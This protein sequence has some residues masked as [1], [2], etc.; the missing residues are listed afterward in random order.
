ML[1]GESGVPVVPVALIG[2][3]EMRKTRWFRSGRLEVRVGEAIAVAEDEEPAELTA[4]LE[5]RLRELLQ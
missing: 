5:A 1:A 3:G 4:R 2:L